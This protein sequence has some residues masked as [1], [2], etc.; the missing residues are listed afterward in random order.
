M[1]KLETKLKIKLDKLRAEQYQK[2]KQQF[3]VINKYL[4]LKIGIFKD[5]I[6][7][8]TIS[9]I[10]TKLMM[11]EHCLSTEYLS[12]VIKHNHRFDLD[13]MPCDL[14]TEKDKNYCKNI[15]A[16]TAIKMPVIA[17]EPKPK[18]QFGFTLSL[19]KKAA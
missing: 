16:K 8:C 18:S 17:S 1:N 12:N 9:K 2:L 11:S 7:H 14:V 6:E 4:P 19:K 3:P 15:M 10:Q 5:L 13:S